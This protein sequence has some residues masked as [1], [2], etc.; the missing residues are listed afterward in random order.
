MPTATATATAI[1]GMSL[2]LLLLILA[3]P[4]SATISF[5]DSS[6]IYTSHQDRHIGQPLLGGYQYMGRMQYVHDNPTLC[7]GTLYPQQT[8]EIVTPSDGLPGA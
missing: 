8:F 6:K 1:V 3:T 7:P 2:S 5:M 4:A